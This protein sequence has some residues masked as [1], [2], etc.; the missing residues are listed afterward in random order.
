MPIIIDNK[1]IETPVQDILNALQ[2]Q[3]YAQH[4]NKLHNIE[5]KITNARITC[6]IHKNGNENKP[7]CDILLVDKGNIPAG[8]VHCFSCGY[9]AN[10]VKFI[11]D[12]LN[13]SYRSATEWLLNFS[14]YSYV[15]D[16]RDINIDIFNDNDNNDNVYSNLS[17]VTIDELKQYDYIHK[18]MFER[19]LNID[20]INKFEVG[21]DPKTDSLTFPVYVDGK[22]L[23]VA[24]R[25][26]SY[27]RFD[28]PEIHPKPI[29]GMCYIDS[30]E[31]IVCESIINCLTCWSYGYQ[32]IALFGTGST[33][34]LNQ[35]NNSNI[36]HFILMFDGDEAGR[37]GADRFKLN[38]KN[39]LI[40]DIKMPNGKDVNDLSKEEFNIL[41]N[42][43][44]YI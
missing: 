16:I 22:C 28:M 17:A 29:Y 37:K 43:I 7:S 18:Y 33:W 38:I 26:V 3:L 35:L 14:D 1:V 24:K 27:K 15:S 34:Q 20:I 12:C 10:I 42:N 39:S 6:P 8:T 13:V 36:R 41:L 5:Y 25:R 32:A 11:A 4:I 31:V 19:K 2:Q 9:K 21:Y 40:T 23:F 30:N 44:N